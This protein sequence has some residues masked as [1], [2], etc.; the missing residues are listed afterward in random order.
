MKVATQRVAS[1]DVVFTVETLVDVS[2]SFSKNLPLVSHWNLS[3]L[4]VAHSS[5]SASYSACF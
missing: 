4:T 5:G 3:R 1:T 2:T